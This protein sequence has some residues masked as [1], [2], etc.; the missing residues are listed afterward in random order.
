MY[1]LVKNKLPKRSIRHRNKN[2]RF[3]FKES[4]Y[5][6]EEDYFIGKIDLKHDYN[7]EFKS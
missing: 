1:Y 7:K 3:P 4:E 5:L 2:V 6:P